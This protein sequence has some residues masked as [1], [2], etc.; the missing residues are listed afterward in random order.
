MSKQIQVDNNGRRIHDSKTRK[1]LE[2][3]GLATRSTLWEMDPE[4]IKVV[5]DAMRKK[6]DGLKILTAKELQTATM[7]LA[8]KKVKTKDPAEK[9]RISDA[10]K[11]M[12]K[13]EKI[14][15]EAKINGGGV[16]KV[17]FARDKNADIQMVDQGKN[18]SEDLQKAKKAL[19]KDSTKSMQED[20]ARS[21]N[22]FEL[23]R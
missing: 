19:E 12:N 7:V 21:N 11:A 22:P 23:D 13:A 4:K 10:I 3:M 9:E 15:K 20:K 2:S 8:S 17:G 16:Q 6:V 14:L 5:F 1:I 18:Y